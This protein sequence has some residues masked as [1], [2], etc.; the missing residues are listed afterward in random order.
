MDKYSNIPYEEIPELTP[1]ELKTLGE[2][3]WRKQVTD[4]RRINK[5][6]KKK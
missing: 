2:L 5:E 1:E 3:Q 6:R 4:Q